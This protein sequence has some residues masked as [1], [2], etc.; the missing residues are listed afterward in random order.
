MKNIFFIH[1]DFSFHDFGK[2]PLNC[3]E[4]RSE[5]VKKNPHPSD[6]GKY[7]FEFDVQTVR[8]GNLTELRIIVQSHHCHPFHL[9]TVLSQ[10]IHS[11]FGHS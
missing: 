8:F 5:S 1:V 9:R 6:K 3:I 4:R 7:S 11:G 10:A 2:H